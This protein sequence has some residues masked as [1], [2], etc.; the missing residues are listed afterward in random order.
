MVMKIGGDEPIRLWRAR[1]DGVG[2]VNGDLRA[3]PTIDVE[4]RVLRQ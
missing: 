2:A 1:N 3:S 4:E